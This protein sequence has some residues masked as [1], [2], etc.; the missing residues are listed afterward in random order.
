MP[1]CDRKVWCA[2]I[3]LNTPCANSHPRLLLAAPQSRNY[4]LKIAAIRKGRRRYSGKEFGSQRQRRL[5][6]P[7][8]FTLFE[9]DAD[10]FSNGDVLRIA[11]NDIHHHTKPIRQID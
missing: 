6:H 10:R 1:K 4:F 5:R 7:L 9:D 11:I 2:I 3:A 8:A